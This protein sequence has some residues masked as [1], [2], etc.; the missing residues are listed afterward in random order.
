MYV[1][2]IIQTLLKK[3]ANNTCL[4]FGALTSTKEE[5]FRTHS[6]GCGCV[7]YAYVAFDCV[8]RKTQVF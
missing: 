6:G 3:Q 4:S 1:T 8:V 2:Y 5:K 7:L